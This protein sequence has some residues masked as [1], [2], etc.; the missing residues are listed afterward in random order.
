MSFLNI[1][2]FVKLLHLRKYVFL[3]FL[4]ELSVHLD[5]SLPQPVPSIPDDTD[6]LIDWERRVQIQDG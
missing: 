6:F 1:M 3:H 4:E 5:S 2:F